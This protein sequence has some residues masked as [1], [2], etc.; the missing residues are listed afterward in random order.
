MVSAGVVDQDDFCVKEAFATTASTSS[1]TPRS[2]ALLIVTGMAMDTRQKPE[3]GALG[4]R[5]RLVARHRTALLSD[6]TVR[7]ASL[8]PEFVANDSDRAFTYM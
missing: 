4:T 3:G 7:A 5:P 8:G 2:A 1:S 6:A